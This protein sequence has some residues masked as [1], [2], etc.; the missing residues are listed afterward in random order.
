VERCV[1]HAPLDV[2]RDRSVVRLPRRVPGRSRFVIAREH[3][4]D[5]PIYRCGESVAVP[6]LRPQKG[7]LEGTCVGRK[8]S[9]P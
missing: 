9:P 8:D 1:A 7:F 4:A 2:I 3:P 6:A 5:S